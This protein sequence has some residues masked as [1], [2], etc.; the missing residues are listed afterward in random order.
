MLLDGLITEP[1]VDFLAIH[2]RLDLIFC[3]SMEQAA[4]YTSRQNGQNLFIIPQIHYHPEN[5][6]SIYGK[7]IIKSIPSP[8]KRF[9]GPRGGVVLVQE[10]K[11][12]TRSRH[13]HPHVV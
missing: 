7:R 12:T 10:S 2:I 4:A 9:A 1:P 6:C 3:V 8:I 13:H 11:K 5:C